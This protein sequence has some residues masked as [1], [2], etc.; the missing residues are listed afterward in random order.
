M[1]SC[2]TH[3]VES[4]DTKYKSANAHVYTKKRKEEKTN[5]NNTQLGDY[6]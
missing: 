3:F 4:V 2:A 5:N 6:I 1:M